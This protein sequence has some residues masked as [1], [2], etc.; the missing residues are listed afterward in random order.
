MPF[1][2]KSYRDSLTIAETYAVSRLLS[3]CEDLRLSE[4]NHFCFRRRKLKHGT[5]G[6]TEGT[7]RRGIRGKQLLGN[8]KE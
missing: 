1:L 4:D 5:E 6:K 7:G 2:T 3:G 8:I